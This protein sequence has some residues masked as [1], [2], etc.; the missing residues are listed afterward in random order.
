MTFD[1]IAYWKNRKWFSPKAADFQLEPLLNLFQTLDFKT[2]LDIGCGDGRIGE[3]LLNHFNLDEYCGNDISIESIKTANGRLYNM[4]NKTIKR[5]YVGP[6]QDFFSADKFDLTIIIE[7]LM[8]VP[9]AEIRA[10][11]EKALKETNKYIVTLDYDPIFSPPQLA[12]H[13]F[14]HNY[15]EIFSK[16]GVHWE[17]I[18][19]S[20]LQTIFKV[21][22]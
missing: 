20:P 10:F 6:F 11:I 1:P 2:V 19:I 13:N 4:K 12:E 22:K 8:H 17:A 5:F 18:R 16:L 7:V 15:R 9:P 21:I 3:L 14:L